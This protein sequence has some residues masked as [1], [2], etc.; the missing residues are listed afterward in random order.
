MSKKT[1]LLKPLRHLGDDYSSGGTMYVFPSASED[2][3]LNLNSNVNG[4]ALS[5]YALLDIPA[6]SAFSYAE[7]GMISETPEGAAAA[8]AISLQNYMMNFETLLINDANYNYA[9]L[10]TVSE[11]VFW[12]WA[13]K[14]G[15]LDVKN[16]ALVDGYSNIYYDKKHNADNDIA[17]EDVTLVKC[18][19][20]IDAG[21][22]LS[23]DFGMFNETYVN[24]PTSYG[25]GPV[26]FKSSFT[27]NYRQKSYQSQ[28]NG[29][30]LEGREYDQQYTSYLGDEYPI[31]DN[32]KNY[33]TGNTGLD[34]LELV[35][36]LNTL[37][38]VMRRQ[39][40]TKPT[41]A[42]KDTDADINIT[43]Y[44]D[45]NVDIKEQ[46]GIDNE[47]NFNAILLYYSIYN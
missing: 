28:T 5:H 3:G 45:I 39:Y 16:L 6:K 41:L 20:A 19:G 42:E 36:D 18:F 34:G 33:N 7:S 15:I 10:N 27:N 44:D 14:V 2:I 13:K 22:S 31:Y 9:D 32:G 35:K 40:S 47:F 21:N 12:H 11:R 38:K 24:I 8:I 1:P 17:T 37:Q 43:S 26:F 23:T 25:A 4:V 29:G 46:F 30:A